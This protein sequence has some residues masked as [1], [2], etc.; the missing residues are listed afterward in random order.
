MSFYT[1]H[2]YVLA[3]GSGLERLHAFLQSQWLPA[4]GSRPVMILEGVVVSPLPQV[5]VVTGHASMEQAQSMSVVEPAGLSYESLAVHHLQSTAYSPLLV[6]SAE[7]ASARYF[8]YRLYQAANAAQMGPLHERFAGPEIPIFHRC[9]IHPVLYAETT[10][11]L[12]MPNLVYFTPFNSLAA[13][14]ACWN[15][16]RSDPEWV[17]VRTEHAALHGPVPKSIEVAIYKAAAYSPVR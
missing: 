7:G 4:A 10:A 9:G 14:E 1:V 8:E 5:L 11:G 16:F 12:K 17:K 2:Q 15:T 3:Q 13:R 6:H